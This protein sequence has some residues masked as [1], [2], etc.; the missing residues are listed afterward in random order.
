M[1]RLRVSLPSPT[2]DDRDKALRTEVFW[3]VLQDYPLDL[4]EGAVAWAIRSLAYFPK[5]VELIVW[6][7]SAYEGAG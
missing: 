3:D 6:I 2:L 5:P 1:N 4:V 7:K